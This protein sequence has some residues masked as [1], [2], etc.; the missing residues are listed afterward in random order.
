[1]LDWL[2][3]L[4]SYLYDL[5]ISRFLTIVSHALMLNYLTFKD[6]DI[7]MLDVG[8]G[9]GLPLHSILPQ[10]PQQLKVVGIDI[11]PAYVMTSK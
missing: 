8:C 11:D 2:K 10:L 9:T 7:S 6:G 4:P 5:V 1:M 3:Q